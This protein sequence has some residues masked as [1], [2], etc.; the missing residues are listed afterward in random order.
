MHINNTNV[1]YDACSM[2][3]KA[4]NK[5]KLIFNLCT[6]HLSYSDA[7]IRYITY[8][9]IRIYKHIRTLVDFML[10]S[11]GVIFCLFLDKVK[12]SNCRIFSSCNN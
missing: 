5:S 3:P 10:I 1:N 8:L 6:N 4:L 9:A 2:Q 12:D 7:V 11:N